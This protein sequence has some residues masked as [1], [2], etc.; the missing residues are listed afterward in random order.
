[1]ASPECERAIEDAVR[2]GY[3]LLKF[4]SPNDVG[5]TGGHQWGYYIPKSENVRTLFTP[6]PPN[7]GENHTHPIHIVW[8]DGRETDSNVKW[9]GKRTRSEY[10]ITAFG[11]DFPFISHHVVGDLLVLVVVEKQK[12]IRAYVLDE[13]EDIDEITAQLGVSP[14]KT[15]ALYER[16]VER[17]ET[18]D[19]C[20]ERNFRDFAKDLSDFPTGEQ[21][22][23]QTWK[24]L[25]ECVEAF[26]RVPPDKGLLRCMDTEFN[27]FKFVERKLCQADLVRAFKDVDDFIAT[28]QT[29]LQR[30]KSRAGRSLENHV[31]QYLK[32]AGIPYEMRPN[33]QGKPDVVIPGA[34]EYKD[35]RYP[36]N[37]LFILGVKRTCR[38]RWRQVVNEAK[39]V[40]HK[41]VLTIE[42]GISGAQ[43]EEMHESNVILVVP[44]PLHSQYP[45]EERAKVVISI[46]DFIAEVR[47]RL[48]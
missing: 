19:E 36:D 16:G 23:A 1:M 17:V 5:L 30:R 13:E 28:A 3:A 4:I 46:Q 18:E 44:K 7:R 35:P 42:Q 22:S 8:Q 26:K 25:E 47:S 37:K 38:D 31:E 48:N 20:V 29:L 27:L 24:L 34:K 21:F 14:A 9:Y 2:Y 33:I 43:L 39:R 40:K 10:R 15:W 12:E 6:Q 41:H 32:V 45:P 11:K